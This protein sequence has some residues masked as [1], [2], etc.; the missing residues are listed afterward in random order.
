MGGP[1]VG[2]TRRLVS[3]ERPWTGL[4]ETVTETER[5]Q[6][7]RVRSGYDTGLVDSAWLLSSGS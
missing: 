2:C 4:N 6:A 5:R 3:P 7:D 1:L